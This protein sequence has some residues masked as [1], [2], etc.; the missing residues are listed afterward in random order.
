MKVH[1]VL[2]FSPFKSIN[3]WYYILVHLN[4]SIFGEFVFRSYINHENSLIKKD[5]F[6]V[7]EN[8]FEKNIK[9]GNELLYKTTLSRVLCF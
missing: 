1:L 9:I 5:F 3:I 4:L 6:T 8:I 7:N 2:H